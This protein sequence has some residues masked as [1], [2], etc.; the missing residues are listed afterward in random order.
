MTITL[1]KHRIT[2]FSFRDVTQEMKDKVVNNIEAANSYEYRRQ[3]AEHHLINA[4]LDDILAD[5]YWY[6]IAVNALQN[7]KGN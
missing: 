4:V 7:L 6:E 5:P 2:L 3:V 1:F